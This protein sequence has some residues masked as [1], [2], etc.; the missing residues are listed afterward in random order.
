MGVEKTGLILKSSLCPQ[1]ASER[2]SESYFQSSRAK[3]Q[4]DKAKEII[5][6]CSALQGRLEQVVQVSWSPLYQT[7]L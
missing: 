4:C 2:A 3:C 1:I 7:E 5:Q 6:K